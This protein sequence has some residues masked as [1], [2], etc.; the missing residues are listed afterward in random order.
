MISENLLNAIGATKIIKNDLLCKRDKR[1]QYRFPKSR[2]KRI[3]K[4][5]SKREANYKYVPDD[6]VLKAA[7]ILYMSRRVF[8]KLQKPEAATKVIS[9]KLLII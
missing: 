1:I 2:K 8:N 9:L 3:R 4:K 7:N 6:I 5:W